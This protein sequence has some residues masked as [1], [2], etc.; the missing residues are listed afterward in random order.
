MKTV[1]NLFGLKV[2][3]DESHGTLTVVGEGPEEIPEPVDTAVGPVVEDD[4]PSR[5]VAPRG[6]GDFHELTNIHPGILV[7]EPTK[8]SFQPPNN[9]DAGAG[10]LMKTDDAVARDGAPDENDGAGVESVGT[11]VENAAAPATT[12]RSFI[13]L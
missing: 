4:L 2:D 7:V 3:D 5:H 11:G 12:T 9:N 1:L 10:S 13:T 8:K 6:A